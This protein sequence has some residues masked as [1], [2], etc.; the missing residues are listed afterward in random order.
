MSECFEYVL[1]KE[2]ISD[3]SGK[4]LESSYFMEPEEAAF[5]HIDNVLEKYKR[6]SIGFFNSL[7]I[8]C[9]KTGEWPWAVVL[10]KEEY[11]LAGHIVS[12]RADIEDFTF[13]AYSIESGYSI[14]EKG[15]PPVSYLMIENKENFGTAAKKSQLLGKA[16]DL[17]EDKSETRRWVCIADSPSQDWIDKTTE[18]DDRLFIRLYLNQ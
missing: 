13:S 4:E 3:G 15:P 17:L 10:F 18:N 7:D 9:R 8:T 6:F 12:I 14:E 16:W 1:L 5:D 11:K 2:I